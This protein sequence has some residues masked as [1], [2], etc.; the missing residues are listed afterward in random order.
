[1]LTNQFS[2]MTY[3]DDLK[4]SNIILTGQTEKN[5]IMLNRQ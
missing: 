1:M 2:N 5:T 3:V 4:L